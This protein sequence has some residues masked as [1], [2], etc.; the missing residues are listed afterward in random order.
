MLALPFAILVAGLC[1]QNGPVVALFLIF[2]LLLVAYLARQL[3][4]AGE[5]SRQQS[6]M[7]EKLEQLGRDIINA[8][9]DA[10]TLPELLEAHV[11]TMFPSGRVAVWMDTQQY[12]YKNPPD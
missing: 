10:S 12:L 2:G 8:P 6:R 9:P 3:S 4:R 5:T 11:P 7:L 1:V